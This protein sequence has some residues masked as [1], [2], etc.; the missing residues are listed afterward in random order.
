MRDK[1]RIEPFAKEIAE[2][3]K[4]VPDWRFGQLM[5]NLLGYAQQKTNRDIFFIEDEEMLSILKSF[6]EKQ[7][8]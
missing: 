7:D 8:G 1:N 4:N 6:F 3:W 5:S 2:L